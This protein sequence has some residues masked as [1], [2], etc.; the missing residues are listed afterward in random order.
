MN[1]RISKNAS[2][3]NAVNNLDPSS[4]GALYVVATPIGNLA[5]IS[6]RALRVLADVSCVLAEDTRHSKRLFNHY[7]ISTKLRACHEHNEADLVSWVAAQLNQG[8]DLAL[9]SD[10]GTPLISDPGFVIVRAL[11]KLGH[12][13]CAVPGASSI[14]A[15]LSIGG[16][17]TDSFVF[18][19]FLPAKSAAR[20]TQLANYLE[21]S[22]TIVVLESSHRINNCLVDIAEVLGNHRRVVIAREITKKFE[23]VLDGTVAE[24]IERL[25]QDPDQS[26]GEFV[27]M[28]EGAPVIEKDQAELGA[29]LRV[30]LAE[31]PMKQASGIAAKV[32]GSRKNEVYELAL[33]IKSESEED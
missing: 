2:E 1:E 3:K 22:R 20:K 12:Q 7:G 17:A 11:R 24:L 19:G 15:A 18:D 21:Q 33:A 32:T 4:F 28:I 30:L 8:Q 25:A 23:T 29:L 16:L 9:I 31:L 10:A 26:R 14:I 5:D 6:H 27:L 13:I